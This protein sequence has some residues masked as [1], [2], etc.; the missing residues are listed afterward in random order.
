MPFIFYL[1]H[2]NGHYPTTCLFIIILFLILLHPFIFSNN[3]H[4]ITPLLHAFMK[5]IPTIFHLFHGSLSTPINRGHFHL[6]ITCKSTYNLH[7]HK[8]SF[9]LKKGVLLVKLWTQHLVQSLLSYTMLSG[10]CILEGTSRECY[11]WTSGKHYC[12]GLESS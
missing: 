10:C 12:S 1:I 6:Q 2:F 4:I 3:S 5:F 7:T 9:Q 8:E 11:C